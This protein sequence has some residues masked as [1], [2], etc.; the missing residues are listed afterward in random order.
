VSAELLSHVKCYARDVRVA[1]RDLRNDTRSVIDAV[2][3]GVEVVLTRRGHPIAR[4]VPIEPDVDDLDRWLA[5]VTSDPYDS[6]LLDDVERLRR[7]EDD[8]DDRRLGL[9]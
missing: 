5:E 3:R 1:I 2:E 4:I 9:T 6:G 7:D 8:T